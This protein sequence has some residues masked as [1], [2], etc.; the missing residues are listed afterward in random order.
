MNVCGVFELVTVILFGILSSRLHKY[1]EVSGIQLGHAIV[2]QG[3]K[4]EGLEESGVELM[5]MMEKGGINSS[6][7]GML[8]MLGIS[9]AS[10]SHWGGG[11]SY[12]FSPPPPSFF[13][14]LMGREGVTCPLLL[15]R[16][17]NL[18]GN[19]FSRRG[20]KQGN[21]RCHQIEPIMTRKYS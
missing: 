10:S 7:N 11:G 1:S 16:H 13:A 19:Q 8:C 17:F 9:R 18:S 3:S 5:R 12:L 21:K 20:A 6:T 15:L 14:I 4:D 2:A